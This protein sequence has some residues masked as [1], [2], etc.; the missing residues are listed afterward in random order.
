MYNYF[1]YVRI[2]F[3]AQLINPLAIA[4]K[5]TPAL[6]YLCAEDSYLKVGHVYVYVQSV[7]PK[8]FATRINF[9]ALLIKIETIPD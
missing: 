6:D 8:K 7:Q 1:G 4:M 2:T 5:R 9:R 3:V